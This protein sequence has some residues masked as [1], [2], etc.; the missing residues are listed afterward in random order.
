MKTGTVTGKKTGDLFV[1]N[2]LERTFVYFLYGVSELVTTQS[3]I[4]GRER[5][6][7]I[8]FSCFANVS[9]EEWLMVYV[10][11]YK[12]HSGKL[13]NHVSQIYLNL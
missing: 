4:R 5:G 2:R 6:R 9:M 1:I 12:K 7:Q 13:L 3:L 10:D 11:A 8:G